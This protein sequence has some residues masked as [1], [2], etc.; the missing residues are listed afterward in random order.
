MM[1]TDKTYTRAEIEAGIKCLEANNDQFDA[2]P[3]MLRQLLQDL[4]VMAANAEYCENMAINGLASHRD[5]IAGACR[6]TL[7]LYNERYKKR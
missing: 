2:L 3:T 6:A 4:D 7:R 5:A 1:T